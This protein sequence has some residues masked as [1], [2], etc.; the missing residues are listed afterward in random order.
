[1]N[2]GKNIRKMLTKL[3]EMND[4]EKIINIVFIC[5]LGIVLVFASNFFRESTQTEDEKVDKESVQ[6]TSTA[7]AY[8]DYQLTLQSD[9]QSILSQIEGVGDVQ[10]MITFKSVEEKQVAYNKTESSSVTSESD[11]QGGERVTE[12]SSEDQNAIMVNQNGE[13]TPLIITENYPDIKGVIVVAQ[14]AS[15]PNIKY[16]LMKCVENSLDLPA[17]KV[18][19]YPK[20]K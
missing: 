7:N 13:N 9:L 11:N 6:E 17:F 3:K 2:L 12:Q 10:V 16:K 1:M 14:G 19:V 4:K 18:T 15:D 5:L 20:K 8:V